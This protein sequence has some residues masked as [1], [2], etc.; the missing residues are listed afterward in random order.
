MLC[1][2]TLHYAMLYYI[3]WLSAKK[4]CKNKLFATLCINQRNREYSKGHRMNLPKMIKAQRGFCVNAKMKTAGSTTHAK[5]K[6]E[7][8]S[9]LLSWK[10][11]KKH[12]RVKH[13][14]RDFLRYMTLWR[15][16]K[17]SPVLSI[18]QKHFR[19]VYCTFSHEFDKD[20]QFN[21]TLK[22]NLNLSVKF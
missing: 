7:P 12:V 13:A 22:N 18:D 16:Y 3:T 9:S 19:N 14:W 5:P 6:K 8:P 17:S 11:I 10:R 2:T 15:V 1:T 20:L 4:Q 21:Q